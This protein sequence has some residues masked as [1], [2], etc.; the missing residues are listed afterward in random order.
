MLQGQMCLWR[1]VEDFCMCM[2]CVCLWK[3]QGQ[4][5][6]T[7]LCDSSYVR[8]NHGTHSLTNIMCEGI[9]RLGKPG[10]AFCVCM[11]VCKKEN[12]VCVCVFEHL[13]SQHMCLW[14][15][16]DTLMCEYLCTWQFSSESLWLYNI[17]HAYEWQVW[18]GFVCYRHGVHV[19]VCM[20]IRAKICLCGL[21]QILYIWK[22]EREWIWQDLGVCLWQIEWLWGYDW[23]VRCFVTYWIC[24]F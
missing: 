10:L 16:A 21:W 1:Y 3:R 6:F 24:I 7:W 18:S 19:G 5:V 14:D 2:F 13:T 23:H 9:F 8:V 20:I 22:R 11:C 17:L 12:S 15:Y 4:N